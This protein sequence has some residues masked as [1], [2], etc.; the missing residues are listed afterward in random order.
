MEDVDVLVDTITASL[1]AACR[2]ELLGY[3]RA[4][5]EYLVMALQDEQGRSMQGDAV[6]MD[7]MSEAS[8]LGYMAEMRWLIDD[9]AEGD[10]VDDAIQEYRRCHTIWWRKYGDDDE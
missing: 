2:M 7:H 3:H 10:D 1:D 4:A 9:A 6:D 8:L 5:W